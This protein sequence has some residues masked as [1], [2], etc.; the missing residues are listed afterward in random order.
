MEPLIPP[1]W[2]SL[3]FIKGLD[4]SVVEYLAQVATPVRWEKG[5]LVYR[6]GEL[7]SPLYLVEEGRVAI[8]LTVPGKGAVTILTVGPGEVF[9]WSSLFQSRPKTAAARVGIPTTAWAL[10][11]E[12]LRALC[13]A[14]PRFG[15]VLTRR[16]LDVIAHRLQA[17]RI[18]LLDV[19]KD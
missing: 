14:D 10:D 5:T 19:F 17:T 4:P 8:E 11:A 3:T 16:L 13:D 2:Q 18:Q 12:R 9:G 1:S 15:Y 6:E 7:D